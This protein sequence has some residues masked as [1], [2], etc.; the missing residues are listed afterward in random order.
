MA[1]AIAG[2]IAPVD[3]DA[4]AIVAPLRAPPARVSVAGARLPDV[5][6]AISSKRA[7]QCARRTPVR[8]ALARR[9][10]SPQIST[11]FM[12]PIV[13]NNDSRCPSAYRI[14]SF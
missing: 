14:D 4:A 7:H 9:R 10:S 8:R 5:T 6:A 11:E 12:T 3:G 1:G 2:G 13:H